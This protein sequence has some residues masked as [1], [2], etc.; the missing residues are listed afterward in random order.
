MSDTAGLHLK[1]DRLL[2]GQDR[3]TAA[4]G[5]LETAIRAQEA[6]LAALLDGLA[7]NRELL[8]QIVARMSEETGG[9]D[10]ALMLVEMNR[11]LAQLLTDSTRMVEL[12]A[13][14]PDAME[15]AAMDGAIYAATDRARPLT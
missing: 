12:L 3:T 10:L 7:A 2:A 5:A 11:V 14:L 9:Q 13:D 8:A 15:R 4:I 6:G 1:L